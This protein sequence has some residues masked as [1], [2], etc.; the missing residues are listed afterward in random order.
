MN[1]VS[2]RDWQLRTIEWTRGKI[3]DSS[4]PD[5]PY[6]GHPGRG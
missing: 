3:R 1:D 5:G 2:V 4:T 6:L